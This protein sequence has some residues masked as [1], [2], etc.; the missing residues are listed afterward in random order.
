MAAPV[1]IVVSGGLAVINR[2]DLSKLATPL[3][4]ASNGKGTAVTIVADRGLPVNL[5][6]EAGAVWVAP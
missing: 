6:D 1:V 3:T 5:L 2:A 4:V